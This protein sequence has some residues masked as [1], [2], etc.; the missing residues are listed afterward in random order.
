[1]LTESGSKLGEDGVQLASASG[2]DSLLAEFA[3]SIVESPRQHAAPQVIEFYSRIGGMCDTGPTVISM[4]R[5]GR[6]IDLAG[7]WLSV[8]LR[9]P[10]V[11]MRGGARLA[12]VELTLSSR[13]CAAGGARDVE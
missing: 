9:S 8:L 2:C 13:R 12:R 1:V 6:L 4:G 5:E 7:P 11:V 3:D 10:A